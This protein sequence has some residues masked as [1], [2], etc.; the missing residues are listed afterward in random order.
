MTTLEKRRFVIFDAAQIDVNTVIALAYQS[1][2]AKGLDADGKPIITH[3]QVA[4][5]MLDTG[6]SVTLGGSSLQKFEH[7]WKEHVEAEKINLPVTASDPVAAAMNSQPAVPAAPAA[8]P[9]TAP[10]ATPASVAPPTPA[11]PPL[12]SAAAP[13]QAPVEPPA[14]GG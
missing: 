9:P 3:V 1:K 6:S 12:P 4:V 13:P 14:P 2:E 5:V 8:T 11:V 7:W 10:P